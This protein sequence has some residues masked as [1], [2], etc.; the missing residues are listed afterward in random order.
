MI[1]LVLGGFGRQQ[2]FRVRPHNVSVAEGGQAIIPC[3]VGRLQG[4]MQWTQN[5]LTLG[6]CSFECAKFHIIP[7]K[8]S[9]RLSVCLSVRPC[10][11]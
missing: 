2:Y 3:E 5:G 10:Q 9:V 11:K 8:P 4:R 1:F 6:K 7:V